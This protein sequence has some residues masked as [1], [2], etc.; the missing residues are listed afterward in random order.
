V[1]Q[2]ILFF[3]E[4]TSTMD[5]AA[6]LATGAHGHAPVP[7][8]T[9]VVAETQS[10]SRGRFQRHWVSQPGNLYLSVVFRPTLQTLPLLS[11]LSGVAVARSIRKTTGLNP[12]IK[13][14]NDVLLDGKKVA[15]ILLESMLE[16]RSIRYAVVGIGI[17]VGL[18]TDGIAEIAS[19]ATSLKAAAGREAS[20]EG[21]LRYL[22]QDLDTLY[23][24]VAQG[25]SPL[26][27]WRGLL[28]TLGRRVKVSWGDDTY[29]GRGEDVDAL[30]NLQLRLDNG[31]L[32]TLSSGE[33]TLQD[34]ATEPPRRGDSQRVTC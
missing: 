26:A 9:V 6:R 22:L 25:K 28:D 3:Q 2:R 12:R 4:V 29:L 20:R 18:D 16:G 34:L 8:G 27:E 14:P 19:F 23:L 33:V 21:L 5:E 30:G 1:G 32:I 7:E 13:W 10:A 17:N 24:Q 15:G 11:I 31:Q